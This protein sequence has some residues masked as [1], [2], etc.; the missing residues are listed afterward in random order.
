[1]GD[2]HG[3]GEV[4]FEL[5]RDLP[6]E[7]P[8]DDASTLRALAMCAEL[9]VHPDVLDVGCGPGMQTVAL[10]D[11]TGGIVTAVDLHEAF[12]DQLRERA[13]EA[14]VRERILAMRGDMTDLPFGRHS[15]DLIW[16]EG[17]VYIMGVSEA[18]SSWREC[19]RPGGYIVFS[20]LTWLVEDVP[21]A[22]WGFFT[23]AYPGVRDI[24]GNLA[25]IRAADYEV[26]GH[27]TLPAE[28]WWT[29]Y[30]T[31]LEARIPALRERYAGDEAALAVIEEVIDEHA[32][33]RA[34]PD[35]Y[36]YEFYVARLL[37]PD[38]PRPQAEA[39]TEGVDPNTD[40]AAA[41]SGD[42]PSG[43]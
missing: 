13:A 25:R 31:P 9:P 10:A 20:E 28:S 15:F 34:Y 17:A 4:F 39:P 8:G 19:L 2:D 24:A 33:R 37:D 40:G 30:G 21:A 35:S 41:P 27:F 14:G 32:I 38:A 22:A 36:G 29:Y 3:L 1:M 23:H 5:H 12:L 16:C 18:L 11:A 42:S 26:V 6:R 7:G 43:A